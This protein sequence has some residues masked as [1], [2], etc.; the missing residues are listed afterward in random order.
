MA[1]PAQ[2]MPRPPPGAPPMRTPRRIAD[3]A[4]PAELQRPATVCG[5]RGRPFALPLSAR[6]SS[7]A[8]KVEPSLGGSSDDSGSEAPA[9]DCSHKLGPGA[10]ALAGINN[11]CRSCFKLRL[12]LETE[13]RARVKAQEQLA[14][15]RDRQRNVSSSST[16]VPSSPSETSTKGGYG[17]SSLVPTAARSEVESPPGASGAASAASSPAKEIADLD[18]TSRLLEGYRRQVELL[19]RALRERDT[20]EKELLAQQQKLKSDNTASKQGWEA[21][22]AKLLCEVSELESKNRELESAVRGMSVASRATTSTA[23]SAGSRCS[24]VFRMASTPE[25]TPDPAEI[26]NGEPLCLA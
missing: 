21:E 15:L 8:R 25:S 19:Q 26:D 24:D 4:K 22:V 1:A 5:S 3:V 14:H 7:E 16:A 17:S 2:H 13:E 23:A 6:A 20:R 18:G 11:G 12:K 10:L 9:D